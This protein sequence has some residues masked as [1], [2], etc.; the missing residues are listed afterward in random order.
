MSCS[1]TQRESEVF[2]GCKVHDFMHYG[3]RNY[4]LKWE[5]NNVIR[6]V[7][8][9]F[10]FM[11]TLTLENALRFE[12]DVVLGIFCL[13]RFHLRERTHDAGSVTRFSFQYKLMVLNK[14]S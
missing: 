2:K 10:Y 3:Q 13:S 1:G 7:S 8:F 9:T 6:N 12:T 11:L 4:V 5:F 14:L